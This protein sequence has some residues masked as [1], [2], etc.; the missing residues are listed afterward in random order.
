MVRGLQSYWRQL[1][2]AGI[3][4]VVQLDNPF[5]LTHPVYRCVQENPTDFGRCDFD[6]AKAFEESAAPALKEAAHGLPGVRVLDMTSVI[7]PDGDTCP[8]VIGDVLVYRAG[9]HL[10]RTFTVSAEPRLAEA[11]Q[12]VAGEKA[13][14]FSP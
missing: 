10:T 14:L 9:S 11:L 1:Q 6:L 8:A 12:R 4:V 5:P 7:C 3:Q 2:D 13:D